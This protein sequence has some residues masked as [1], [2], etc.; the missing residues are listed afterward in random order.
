MIEEDS[1]QSKIQKEHGTNELQNLKEQKAFDCE[2]LKNA[3][4]GNGEINLT[5]DVK[6]LPEEDDKSK[7]LWKRI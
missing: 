1:V 7:A 5:N 4:E 3:K 6:N 2:D